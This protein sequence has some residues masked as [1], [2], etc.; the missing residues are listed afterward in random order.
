MRIIAGI[1]K[2][3]QIKAP[4]GIK[5]TKD[6]VRK[7]LFDIL[8][9]VE[10]LSFLELFAGSGAVGLEAASRGAKEVVF[11]ES[12]PG[13]ISTI[14]ENMAKLSISQPQLLTKDV[15]EGIKSFHKN[16][17]SFDLVF[18]DPP[19]RKQE[20]KKTLQ[21]IGAYDIVTPLGYVIVEHFKKDLLIERSGGLVFFK[22]YDYGDTSLS[23]YSKTKSK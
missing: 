13:S 20:G 21:T 1:Y 7:A 2:G 8:A 23:F 12:D 11:L 22:R 16:K 15:Y 5:P 14:R 19:Y 18:L 17:K 6:M 9:D 3:R 10:G 4:L